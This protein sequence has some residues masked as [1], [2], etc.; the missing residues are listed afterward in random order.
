MKEKRKQGIDDI[1]ID[2]LKRAKDIWF[3]KEVIKTLPRRYL[4]REKNKDAVEFIKHIMEKAR[5]KGTPIS[6]NTILWI[7]DLAHITWVLSQG[8]KGVDEYFKKPS[9]RQRFSGVAKL[10]NLKKNPEEAAK[11]FN[12]EIKKCCPILWFITGPGH[13]IEKNL[14][15][16]NNDPELIKELVNI[17]MS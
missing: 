15:K 9:A 1:I 5:K 10:L 17:A 4:S 8:Q 7:T 2:E 13:A 6:G 14:S 11:R 12:T 3:I 16:L